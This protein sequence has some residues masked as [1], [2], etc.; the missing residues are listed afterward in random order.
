MKIT[1]E[2]KHR[3]QQVVS[4]RQKDLT[5]ILENVHDSHNIGAVLR[6]C[7]SVG[8]REIFVLYTEP[9]LQKIDKLEMGRR[10]SGG[11]R[12]WIDVHFYTDP[13]PCF[14]HVRRHYETILATH[15]TAEAKNVYDLD[16]TRSVALMF[17]NEHDGLSEGALMYAD[18]NFLIPQMGMVKSLNIS[19]ACAVTLYEGLRQRREAGLYD[20]GNRMTEAEQSDLLAEYLHRHEHRL[21]GKKVLRKN[22]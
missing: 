10:T 17:G 3:F 22:D 19:V 16:L 21:S 12:K 7:D 20:A 8:I 2:R 4:R 18:T 9:E 11:A 15:L 5:V 6:S 1:S 14:A 13:E